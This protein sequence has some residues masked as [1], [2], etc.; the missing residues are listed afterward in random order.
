M[1]DVEYP[2]M[3][4]PHTHKKAEI[5]DLGGGVEPA[6]YTASNGFTSKD[7]FGQSGSASLYI[8]HN[9]D[10]NGNVQDASV[11]A[12]RIAISQGSDELRIDRAAAG[13]GWAPSTIF[14]IDGPTG[15]TKF[16]KLKRLLTIASNATPTINTDNYDLVTITAQAANITSMT[17]NLTGTPQDGDELHIAITGTAARTIA[18][19]AKFEASTVALP[20][21]TVTTNRLDI[22]FIWNAAT[23]KWRCLR[24]V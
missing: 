1:D 15:A 5:E 12:W 24:A 14:H 9:V 16:R 11:S 4:K 19:G 3:V 17:T 21:T 22:D 20:T 8:G 23:S 2:Q 6:E 10:I 7:H 18:W 13:A